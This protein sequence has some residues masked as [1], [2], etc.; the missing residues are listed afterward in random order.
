[1]PM[2]RAALVFV[3]PCPRWLV[4]EPAVVAGAY[5]PLPAFHGKHLAHFTQTSLRHPLTPHGAPTDPNWE[6]TTVQN[7]QH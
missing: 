3:L 6:K 2:P 5:G 7:E 1:M 4:P